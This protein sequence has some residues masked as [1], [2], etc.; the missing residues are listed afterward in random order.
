M[1]KGTSADAGQEKRRAGYRMGM[2]ILVHVNRATGDEYGYTQAEFA[3][4]VGMSRTSINALE[5]GDNP[6]SFDM[7]FE[8]FRALGW[9]PFMISEMLECVFDDDWSLIADPQR[10]EARRR[11]RPLSS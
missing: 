9:R 8:V 3:G 6:M 7:L 1:P 11:K 5:M 2:A 4:K 10:I